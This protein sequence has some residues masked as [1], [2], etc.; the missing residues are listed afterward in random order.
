MKITSTGTIFAGK[1]ATKEAISCFPS[2]CPLETGEL[3]ATFQVGPAKNHADSSI[4]LSRSQNGG[5]SW[6][7]PVR[8]WQDWAKSK[9]LTTHIAYI[10]EVTP[11]R[12]LASIMLC[13][14]LGNDQLPFFNPETGGVLPLFNAISES[15]DGG[16]SWSEP[17]MITSA[18]FKNVPI[19]ISGPATRLS[20]GELWISFE[21]CKSYDDPGTWKHYACGL[22][23]K[24][25]GRTWDETV[26]TAHDPNDRFC[27]WD[28]RLAV[29]ADG[30]CIDFYWSFDRDI[31]K[32]IAVHK[33]ICLDAG[34]SWPAVP[35]DTHLA[36]QSTW[37][38]PLAGDEIVALTVDRF[39][40]KA[41]KAYLSKDL[42]QTWSDSI[43]VYD[44]VGASC[45][46]AASLSEGVAQ[47][48]MWSF[49]LPSGFRFGERE[50][51]MTWYAGDAESTRIEWT[52]IG[53]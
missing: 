23:S 52:R 49:G 53:V 16:K 34:R 19:G 36:G 8:P 29:L 38:V 21:T 22:V 13:D 12:L 43:V 4:F 2:L 41:I 7:E 6:S 39:G 44:H 47:I 11:G 45:D 31:E 9:K 15:L 28:H 5:K 1:A 37:P 32:D 14:H 3:L 30:R 42:G 48:E 50:V 20:S 33:S 18:R 24:D 17:Q 10:A 40:E 51:M 25:D 26:V 35:D 46:E 27:Y